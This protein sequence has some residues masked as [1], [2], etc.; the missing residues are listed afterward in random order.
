[1]FILPFCHNIIQQNEIHIHIIKL[2]TIGGKSLWEEN[3]TQNIERNILNPN[4]IWQKGKSIKFNKTLYL[5]QVDTQKTKLDEFYNWKEI[6]LNTQSDIFCWR[7]YIYLSG[8]NDAC[9]LEIPD[10]EKLDS[11]FLKDII[12]KIISQSKP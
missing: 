6:D 11:F 2:L 10:D 9:W 7:E 3:N 8:S 12:R 4:D 5:C 1:M